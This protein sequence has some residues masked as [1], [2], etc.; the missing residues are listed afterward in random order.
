MY[1]EKAYRGQHVIRE[2]IQSYVD[3]GHLWEDACD[4]LY[5]QFMEEGLTSSAQ[6]VLEQKQP[7]K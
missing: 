3:Q 4:M 2:T 7:T 5:N 6:Q 1:K